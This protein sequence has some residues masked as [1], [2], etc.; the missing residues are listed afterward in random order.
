MNEN[1]INGNIYN[2]KTNFADWWS[3]SMN[4]PLIKEIWLDLILFGIS[5][6]FDWELR[7]VKFILDMHSKLRYPTH[8]ARSPFK[9]YDSSYYSNRSNHTAAHSEHLRKMIEDDV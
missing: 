5:T 7:Q 8:T 9:N 6:G 1:Q 3:D 4:M 2:L